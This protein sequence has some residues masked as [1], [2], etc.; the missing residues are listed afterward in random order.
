MSSQ[1]TTGTRTGGGRQG[2][3]TAL[4]SSSR[5]R[6]DGDGDGADSSDSP[7]AGPQH[8]HLPSMALEESQREMNA[9]TATELAEIHADVS[10]RRGL[11]TT[12]QAAL[13]L[14]APSP[15][16]A[17][18]AAAA[19][20]SVSHSACQAD[21]LKQLDTA[22]AY[23]PVGKKSAYT[24]ACELNPQLVDAKRKS[25]FLEYAD[26]DPT[27][28]ADRLALYWEA[29]VDLFGADRAFK[30]DLGMRQNEINAIDTRSVYRILPYTDTAGRPIVSITPSRRNTSEYSVDDEL[31][32]LWYL[33]EC[34][35]A[36]DGLRGK[37]LVIVEDGRNWPLEWMFCSRASHITQLMIKSLPLRVKAVHLCYASKLASRA[38]GAMKFVYSRSMRLR[39]RIYCGSATT[40]LESLAQHSLPKRVL[41]E[42]LG[43]DISHLELSRFALSGGMPCILE[44]HVPDQGTANIHTPST[45]VVASPMRSEKVDAPNNQSTESQRAHV[46][47]STMDILLSSADPSCTVLPEAYALTDNERVIFENPKESGGRKSDERMMKA[48]I[49]TLRYPSADRFEVLRA[50][51]FVFPLDENIGGVGKIKKEKTFVDAQGIS[52]AQ[53]KNQLRRRIKSIREMHDQL[54]SSNG[55][56]SSAAIAKRTLKKKKAP[57]SKRSKKNPRK[58]RKSST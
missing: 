33:L 55:G 39:F 6:Q 35:V 26:D 14:N 30:S 10:G 48:V 57:P 19:A 58:K 52:L 50:A 12:F 1:Q 49:L 54:K 42:H 11:I 41:P 2:G 13:R 8:R 37:G 46:R 56:P 51:G 5:S 38:I 18:A 20:P 31:R 9:L 3:P 44:T 23:L 32:G 34:L 21:L 47:M 40:I 45:D 7:Y 24:F 25:T 29:R 53:R 17:A 43:G 36:D 22:I 28:A 27:A 4:T 16:S 15:L